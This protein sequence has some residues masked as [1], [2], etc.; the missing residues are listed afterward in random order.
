MNYNFIQEA[1]KTAKKRQIKRSIDSYVRDDFL[2]V[3]VY[4]AAWINN[5]EFRSAIDDVN[6]TVQPS[7]YAES[8]ISPSYNMDITGEFH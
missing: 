3:T 1:I 8:V 6:V 4:T 7:R 5:R 2:K